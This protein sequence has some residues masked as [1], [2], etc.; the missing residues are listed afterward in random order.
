VAFRLVAPEPAEQELQEE[1]ARLLDVLLLPPTEW[2][3]FVAGHVKL[4][5]AE[6][7]RLYRSGLKTGWPDILILH[8]GLFGVELKT[9]RGRLSRT[10]VV[11]NS[12]GARLVIGQ[13]ERFPAL[14]AAGFRD[15]AVVTST[16]ELVSQLEAW[17]IPLRGRI[18]A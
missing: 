12:R 16:S 17:G 3:A 15:I 4:A 14:I 7:A 8:R 9:S 5:P 11:R 6:R 13:R 18:S 1:V 2:T 10:R